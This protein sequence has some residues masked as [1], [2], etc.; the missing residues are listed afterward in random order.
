MLKREKA[1]AVLELAILGSIIIAAFALAIKHSENYNR[2]QSYM[3]QAFRATLKKAK[4]ANN[5]ASLQTLNFRRLS[6]VTSP[7][8]L[9]ELQMYSGGN[10]ILWSDGK[11]EEGAE[12]SSTFQSGE[13]ETTVDSRDPSTLC[14][15]TET[16]G[17]GYDSHSES[18]T[19]FQK[20]ESGGK[21]VTYKS[22]DAVDS[23]SGSSSMEGKALD[24]AG[25]LGEG[26]VYSGGGIH[27]SRSMQ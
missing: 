23:L 21:I 11:T 20:N 12:G 7:M 6:N 15:T 27:R 18:V 26:G 3:Q 14:G 4:V 2:Q 1:Q 17:V 10:S 13:T 9:G 8:E 16:T 5:S 24:V 19:S 25:D 22:M